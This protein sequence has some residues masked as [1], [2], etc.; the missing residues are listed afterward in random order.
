MEVAGT[1]LGVSEAGPML[2][3]VRLLGEGRSRVKW[4]APVAEAQVP[5]WTRGLRV[6]DRVLCEVVEDPGA[7][8]MLLTGLR[9]WSAGGAVP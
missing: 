6:G 2:V 7:Q 8:R 5:G 1:F 4:F 9:P 3:G